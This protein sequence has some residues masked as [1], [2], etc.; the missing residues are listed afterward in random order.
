M[1]RSKSLIAVGVILC[2][3]L[4]SLTPFILPG[5]ARAQPADSPWPVFGQNPQRTGESPY[6]GSEMPCPKWRFTSGD[7]VRSS[8]AIGANGTI[9]SFDDSCAKEAPDLICPAD[10][11]VIPANPSPDLCE[12]LPFTIKWDHDCDECKYDIQI[13]LDEDFTELTE[14]SRSLY[15][16][17]EEGDKSYLVEGGELLCNTTHYWRIRSVEIENGEESRSCWSESWMFVVGP[18]PGTGVNLTAPA[19]GA[20]NV[21][22]T[23][24]PFTWSMEADAD[25]FHWQLA[26]DAAFTDIVSTA[27]ALNTTGHLYV[28]E[29]N[30]DMPYFWRVTAIKDGVLISQAVGSFTTRPDAVEPPLP[31]E[32]TPSPGRC[33][34][35]TAA[36]GTPMAEEVQIL[37]D[38][39]DRYLLS[40]AVGQALV[41][42]YYGVSPPVAEF[43][44][45]HPS[46]KPIVRT[47]LLPAV[48]MST[49][50][51]NTSV[52]QKAAIVGL[53]VL[54][55]G[56]AALW[57]TRR[58]R[59]GMEYA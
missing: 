26:R 57:S 41:G 18:A 54:V 9:W 29:L 20:T 27:T 5:A 8:S 34:I 14:A 58:R 10:G 13:A 55:A 12:N 52:A 32:P 40:N 56:S 7:R 35:A 15:E 36:Y 33:F 53:L 6:T 31:P 4:S 24:I 43:I 42:F 38:L 17:A 59:R 3:L 1:N 19:I 11:F 21:R 49:V 51:I 39:R 37:R 2:L 25:Q 47:A 23:D 45:E 46:L 16:Q 44:S 30:Y 28:G 22:I 48:A 50:A